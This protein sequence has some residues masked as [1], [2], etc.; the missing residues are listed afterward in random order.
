VLTPSR[1]VALSLLLSP[2]LCLGACVAPSASP[3]T[4]Q[5]VEVDQEQVL[6]ASQAL[7]ATTQVGGDGPSAY[8]ALLHPRFTRWYVGT[9]VMDRNALVAAIEQW[10][11]S[12]ARVASGERD[13]VHLFLHGDQALL[14]LDLSEEFV[15]K[16]GN[17]AGSFAGHVAQTWARS[18][19]EWL[20]IAA[21]IAP[22]AGS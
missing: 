14:R 20:L 2:L 1:A 12:G 21:D 4:D 18:G 13:V 5:D 17:P 22:A 11:L 7:S 8:A 9:D 16:D 3:P 19:D 6:A 10:W 15:D